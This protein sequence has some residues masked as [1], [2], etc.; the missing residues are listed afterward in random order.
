M[1]G[2]IL[3][4]TIICLIICQVASYM[5]Y[6]PRFVEGD[7]NNT[8]PSTQE[9]RQS[10]SQDITALINESIQIQQQ[11]PCGCGGLGWRRVAYLDMSDTTQ[12]CPGE[13]ELITDP[14][15]CGRPAN[16][17]GGTCFSA[18]FS[19]PQNIAYSQVCG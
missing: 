15:S 11:R 18:F 1:R 9:L 19:P 2:L 17:D 10:I 14:R 5:T 7:S 13:W 16:A 6:S 12:T 4:L 3:F 8:C